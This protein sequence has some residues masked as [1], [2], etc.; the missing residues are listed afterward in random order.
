LCRPENERDYG[1][2]ANGFPLQVVEAYIQ[3]R[4]QQSHFANARSIRNVPDC[5]RLRVPSK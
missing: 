4:Q 2:W 3:L 5:A 1:Q